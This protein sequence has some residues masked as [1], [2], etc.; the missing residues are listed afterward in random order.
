[1]PDFILINPRYR[2]GF[3]DYVDTSSP[4][5]Y[6]VHFIRL[7]SQAA[8]DQLLQGVPKNQLPTGSVILS[9]EVRA[10]DGSPPDPSSQGSPEVEAL[11]DALTL[12]AN[13]FGNPN[14]VL[15]TNGFDESTPVF[16]WHHG[17]PSTRAIS[18]S[19]SDSSSH[20]TDEEE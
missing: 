7:N 15:V 10:P 16:I 2:A 6:G 4:A 14:S 11:D 13:S 1:M 3:G 12:V 9:G 8:A 20:E 19:Q 5:S 18:P 17:K